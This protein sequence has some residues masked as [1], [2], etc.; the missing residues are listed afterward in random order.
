MKTLLKILVWGII[1]AS[2]TLG[3]QNFVDL[4]TKWIETQ[5]FSNTGP[6]PPCCFGEK[7]SSVDCYTNKGLTHQFS[8]WIDYCDFNITT[9][10]REQISNEFTIMPNPVR[11]RLWI[12]LLNSSNLGDPKFE[13]FN[14]NGNLVEARVLKNNFIDADELIAG[15]YVLK[16]YQK[17][18]NKVFIKKFVKI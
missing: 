2:E 12:E 18:S 6:N 3:G 9:S 17:N 7:D 5:E 14:S 13:I 11:D 10:V 8:R 16:F 15:I 1:L 4:T